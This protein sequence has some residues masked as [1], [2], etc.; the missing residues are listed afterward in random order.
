MDSGASSL[1]IHNSVVRTNKFNTRKINLNEQ[2]T[3]PGCVSTSCEAKVQIKL[4]ELNVMANTFV[5]FHIS[6]Q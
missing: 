6:S 3:I 2:S 4:P 1:S 5:P